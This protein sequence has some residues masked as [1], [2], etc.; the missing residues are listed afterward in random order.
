MRLMVMAAVIRI[1][2]LAAASLTLSACTSAS[3]TVRDGGDGGCVSG[4][5]HVVEA[6][7]WRGLSEA[8]LTSTEWGS[9]ASVRTQA[10][11]GEIGSGD[12]DVLRV[13]DLLDKRERR[14]V[15]VDVWRTEEGTWRF[16]DWG[17]CID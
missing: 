6:A 10:Q 12:V 17:Q 15:Q 5:V 9:V 7:N 3:T 2:V 11:G 8:M 1:S 13:V 16:G 14:L 4:Y